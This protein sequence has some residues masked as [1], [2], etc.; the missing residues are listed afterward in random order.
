MV[1]TQLDSTPRGPATCEYLRFY[2]DPN[3]HYWLARCFREGRGV[4]R[5]SDMEMY[6]DSKCTVSV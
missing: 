2:E 1:E 5:N 3:P 4:A 6:H